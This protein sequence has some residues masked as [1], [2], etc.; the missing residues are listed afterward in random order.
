MG[1]HLEVTFFVKL[2]YCEIN[3]KS[4]IHLHIYWSSFLYKMVYSI[5]RLIY[6][7]NVFIFLIHKY[8]LH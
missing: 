3:F 8:F 7:I 5:G 6:Y 2:L 1:R 4:D